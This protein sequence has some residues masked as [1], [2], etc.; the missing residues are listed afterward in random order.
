MD[1]LRLKTFFDKSPVARLFKS[2][3][4]PFVLYFLFTQFKATDESVRAHGAILSAL[5]RFLEE[6]QQTSDKSPKGKAEDYLTKWCDENHEWLR[7]RYDEGDSEPRYELSPHTELIFSF[8]NDFFLR[9]STP[10]MTGSRLDSALKELQQIV[11]RS[12]DD[13]NVR[14]GILEE[15][16]LSKELEIEKIRSEKIVAM[17]QPSLVR[18]RFRLAVSLLTQ[19][20]GDFR[21]VE[22]KFK[23]LARDLYA[24]MQSQIEE[25]GSIL[26][27]T[28]DAE[29]ALKEEDQGV[30]F[31]EFYDFMSSTV[32]QNRIDDLLERLGKMPDELISRQGLEDI[33]RLFPFLLREAKKVTKTNNRLSS[34]LR[35]LVDTQHYQ[36]RRKIKTLLSEIRSL[37]FAN[38]SNPPIHLKLEIDE[39]DKLVCPMSVNFWKQPTR[40][41]AEELLP[42]VP[43]EEKRRRGFLQIALEPSIDWEQMRATIK[44][45]TADGTRVALRDILFPETNSFGIADILG[46]VQIAQED[47]HEIDRTS[48][49]EIRIANSDNMSHETVFTIPCVTFLPESELANKRI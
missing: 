4:A 45:R 9:E 26:K 19:L 34:L 35:H 1:F 33:R 6:C 2:D 40:F 21:A 11:D 32:Q 17:D 12:S 44:S 7:R 42:H 20:S 31:T 18:E 14:I 29:S 49:E 28:L 38:A 13:P 15:E 3:L 41:E 24:K 39:L 8:L 22:E 36:R 10:V 27:S 25:R 47:G 23:Q 46:Y 37:M 5:K 30:T 48:H 16:I 43:D